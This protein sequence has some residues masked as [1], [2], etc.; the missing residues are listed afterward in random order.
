MDRSTL[1]YFIDLLMLIDFI[2]LFSTGLIK[3][4]GVLLYLGVTQV[5]GMSTSFISNLHD[6]A[7]ITL[8]C[9]III[10]ILLHLGWFWAKTKRLIGRGK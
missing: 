8:G 10:H 6:W 1:N 3:F 2:I 5:I 7:G 9:L 4:P